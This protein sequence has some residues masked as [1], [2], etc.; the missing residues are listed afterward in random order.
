MQDFVQK[1]GVTMLNTAQLLG[2]IS[3]VTIKCP[4]KQII[5]GQMGQSIVCTS[6]KRTWYVSSQAKIIVNEIA[7]DQSKII[8]TNSLLAQ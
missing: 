3:V 1:D 6:C 8:D 4:C 5:M 2:T 7:A